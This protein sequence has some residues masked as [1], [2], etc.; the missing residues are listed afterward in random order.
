MRSTRKRKYGTKRIN[1]YYACGNWKN[2]GTAVCNSN[3]TRI[4]AINDEVIT[5]LMT[6]GLP[7]EQGNPSF[8]YFFGMN[9]V[10]LKIVIYL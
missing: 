4:K 5:Y 1:E 8:L 2:K 10:N 3:S 6:D 9:C 7:K